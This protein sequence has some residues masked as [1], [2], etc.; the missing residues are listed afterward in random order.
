MY[1]M[2]KMFAEKLQILE[3]EISV[4]KSTISV[5]AQTAE[6]KA[7]KD[8][9]D[10]LDAKIAKLEQRETQIINELTPIVTSHANAI[11]SLLGA[12]NGK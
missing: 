5:D 12:S 8:L 10:A 1:Q 7:M 9:I 2:A 6:R 11:K 4:L 3:E